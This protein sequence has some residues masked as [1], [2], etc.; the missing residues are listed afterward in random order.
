M[1]ARD[2]NDELKSDNPIWL[3]LTTLHHRR[4]LEDIVHTVGLPYGAHI[5]LRYRKPYVDPTLWH[6]VSTSFDLPSGIALIVLAG[7]SSDE[8]IDAAPLRT[9]KIFKAHCEGDLLILDISLQDFANETSQKRDFYKH[10]EL[11][12][13]ALPQSL[14]SERSSPG[15]YLQT[16]KPASLPITATR[17]VRGWEKA[18]GAFFRIDEIETKPDTPPTHRM[19]FLYFINNLPPKVSSDLTSSGVLNLEMG[20]RYDIELHTICRAVTK[21][22]NAPLGEILLD[23]SHPSATFT[24][25]RRVRIDSRRDVKSVGVSTAPL[26][27]TTEGHLSVRTSI[28]LESREN[29]DV[30][31]ESERSEENFWEKVTPAGK[32]IEIAVARYDFPTKI[33]KIRPWI[34]SGLI[35]AATALS[36][37]KFSTQG[38]FKITDLI[39]PVL[40]FVFTLFGLSLGLIKK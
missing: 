17:S 33:G 25:S 4:F 32:R 11:C 30:H 14:S 9:G 37:Y 3:C 6:R 13:K 10:L 8:V 21:A 1:R 38:E 22:I 36:V 2:L 15:I 19:P 24:S 35:A 31:K 7:A 27:R 20:K 26:F 39:I 29:N 16:I 40:V 34:A 5:R 18:A 28:F 12:S 23:L